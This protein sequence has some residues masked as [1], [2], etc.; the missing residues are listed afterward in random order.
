[1]SFFRRTE[2]RLRV[3]RTIRFLK[4]HLSAFVQIAF[5]DAQDTGNEFAWH[6]DTLKHRFIDNQNRF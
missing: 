4:H 2:G 3:F 5:Y 6:F 1:M